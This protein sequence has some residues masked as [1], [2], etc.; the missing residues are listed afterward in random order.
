VKYR[1]LRVTVSWSDAPYGV[2]RE[3]ADR[4]MVIGSVVMWNVRGAFPVRK[5]DEVRSSDTFTGPAGLILDRDA[6]TAKVEGGVLPPTSDGPRFV[7][8]VTPVPATAPP[9]DLRPW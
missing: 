7:C 5:A 4:A 8:D 9:A 1:D 2:D 3:P 6:R